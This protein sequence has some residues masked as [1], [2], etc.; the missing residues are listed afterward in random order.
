MLPR[1][2]YYHASPAH[3]GANILSILFTFPAAGGSYEFACEW[4]LIVLAVSKLVL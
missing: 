1:C 2:V 4:A 3:G